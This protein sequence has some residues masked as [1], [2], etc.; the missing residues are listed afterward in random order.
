MYTQLSTISQPHTEKP[1]LSRATPLN[2]DYQIKAS[3]HVGPY[4][5]GEA[6]LQFSDEPRFW[7]PDVKD[8]TPTLEVEF[9]KNH[10]MTALEVRGDPKVKG[11]IQDAELNYR[12][13]VFC[14]EC[15]APKVSKP[16][17]VGLS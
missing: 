5:A 8:L 1:L 13:L 16:Q 14:D 3:T 12:K 11:H 10:I 2:Q 6:I 9:N 15:S 4:A 7:C 17:V